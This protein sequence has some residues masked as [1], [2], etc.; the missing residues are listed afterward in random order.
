MNKKDC[1]GNFMF[2][3]IYIVACSIH[4]GIYQGN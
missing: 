3:Q 2:P 4:K 1:R